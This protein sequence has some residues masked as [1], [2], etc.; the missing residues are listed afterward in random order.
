MREIGGGGG[1][2]LIDVEA[3]HSTHISIII[4]IS[5]QKH[6]HSDMWSVDF[7]A[8]AWSTRYIGYWTA[9]LVCN[10]IILH[11]IRV[12]YEFEPDLYNL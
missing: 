8:R 5:A 11:R 3:G 2:I 6:I 1:V 12:I 9:A 7:V 4:I 10:A